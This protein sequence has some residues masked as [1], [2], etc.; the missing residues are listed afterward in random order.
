M[1]ASAFATRD[2]AVTSSLV[3]VYNIILIPLTPPS[4]MKKTSSKAKADSSYGLSALAI[5]GGNHSSGGRSTDNRVRPGRCN[6]IHPGGSEDA[7]LPVLIGNGGA[8]H[9]SKGKC[10]TTSNLRKK[11]A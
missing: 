8:Y 1:C 11:N 6:K 5:T 7:E 4:Q 9:K 3:I 2:E 10:S